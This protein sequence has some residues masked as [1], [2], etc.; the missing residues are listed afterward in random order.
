LDKVC[1]VLLPA[2]LVVSGGAISNRGRIAVWRRHSEQLF[3]AHRDDTLAKLLALPVGI[4]IVGGAF[5]GERRLELFDAARRQVIGINGSGTTQVLADA[6]VPMEVHAAARLG[7]GWIVAGRGVK[8][9]AQLAV[10]GDDSVHV[11]DVPAKPDASGP[12]LAG[13]AVFLRRL[14][15]ATVLAAWTSPPYLLAEVDQSGGVKW[16]PQVNDTVLR[17]LPRTS[18]GWNLWS[19]MA[20]IPVQGKLILQ[21]ISDLGSDRRMVVVRDGSGFILRQSWSTVP[22]GLIQAS[23]NGE[24]IL[25]FARAPMSRLI[26]YAQRD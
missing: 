9:Q 20:A 19:G 24:L 16:L 3:H 6:K 4:D 17:A 13:D 21:T 10:I 23:S 7:R 12:A 5:V 8:G 25:A 14:D 26:C 1:D 18:A 15:D 11:F 2:P 22:V